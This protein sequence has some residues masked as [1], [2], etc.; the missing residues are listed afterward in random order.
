MNLKKAKITLEK[1]NSLYASMSIEEGNTSAIE[2]DLMLSYIRQLYEAFL[3][4]ADGRLEKA[5][6]ADGSGSSQ[7]EEKPKPRRTYKPPRII[8]IPEGLQTSAPHKL[9]SRP[10]TPPPAPVPKAPPAPKEEPAAAEPVKTA[11]STGDSSGFSSS[12]EIEALFEHK[13][14]KELSEKLSAR[15]IQDL[16]K[17]LAIN[18]RLL[19]MNELFGKDL[20]M[21]NDTLG[22]LNEYSRLSEAKEL[23]VSLAK[24]YEWTRDDRSSVAKDFIHLVRRRYN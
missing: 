24:R 21:L 18:D 4:T 8:E 1:I 6:E 3:H 16:T 10:I 13:A 20:N 2:R 11:P 9:T 22:Q 12:P 5:L 23:L 14:A 17:A 19:Y 15:P 7:A